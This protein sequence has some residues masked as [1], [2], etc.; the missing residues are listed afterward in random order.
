[1]LTSAGFTSTGNNIGAIFD[2]RHHTVTVPP[3]FVNLDF[4]PGGIFGGFDIE[5]FKTLTFHGASNVE[6]AS[7]QIIDPFG[8]STT[9]L[10]DG[11]VFTEI[12]GAPEPGSMLLLVTG[13][14]GLFAF[15]RRYSFKN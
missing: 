3:F 6:V 9:P 13:G 14:L 5:V 1:V 12:A 8:V 15:R 2:A 11:M 7:G 10:R 4:Y